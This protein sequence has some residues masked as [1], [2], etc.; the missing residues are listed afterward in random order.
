MGQSEKS[1][2]IKELQK[3]LEPSKT[4]KTY[5]LPRLFYEELELDWGNWYIC[6]NTPSLMRQTI[7]KKDIVDNDEN[8]LI[9]E[10]SITYIDLVEKLLMKKITKGSTQGENWKK[11][12][13]HFKGEA[14]GQQ[15]IDSMTHIKGSFQN[16]FIM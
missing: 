9:P 11:L 10:N 1:K 5:E 3:E 16:Y 2:K 15:I 6:S 8:I 7:I 14:L 12:I 4:L 13:K